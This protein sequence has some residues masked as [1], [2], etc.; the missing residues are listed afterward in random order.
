MPHTI[1][2]ILLAL[3]GRLTGLFFLSKQGTIYAKKHKQQ[4]QK[5]MKNSGLHG[6]FYYI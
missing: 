5:Q 6:C 4:R 1:E 2:K 3:D